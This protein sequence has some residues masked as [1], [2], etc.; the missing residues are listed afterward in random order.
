MTPLRPGKNNF[1][2]GYQTHHMSQKSIALV[3]LPFYFGV[4]PSHPI[5]TLVRAGVS[6]TGLPQGNW[7]KELNSKKAREGGSCGQKSRE[8]GRNAGSDGGRKE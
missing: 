3:F 4:R 5:L 7:G 1:A 8:E 6:D 2:T